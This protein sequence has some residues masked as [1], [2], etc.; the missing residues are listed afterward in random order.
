MAIC[1]GRSGQVF[2]AQPNHEY[3]VGSLARR[4]PQTYQRWYA[5]CNLIFVVARSIGISSCWQN[6]SLVPL[7][8]GDAGIVQMDR[9]IRI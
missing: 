6:A 8:N 1:H 9:I 4:S 5:V 7:R 3:A 2:Q